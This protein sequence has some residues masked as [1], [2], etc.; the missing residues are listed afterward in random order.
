MEEDNDRNPRQSNQK[1]NVRGE[2]EELHA[3]PQGDYEGTKGPCRADTRNSFDSDIVARN[4]EVGVTDVVEE[5]AS[6]TEDEDGGEE[7]NE[8]D[9]EEEYLQDPLVYDILRNH[10]VGCPYFPLVSDL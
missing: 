2:S 3:A 7:L 9:D 6:D 4:I 1:I 5:L 8:S 10:C